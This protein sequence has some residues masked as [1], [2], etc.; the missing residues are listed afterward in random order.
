MEMKEETTVTMVGGMEVKDKRV[1]SIPDEELKA[2][3]LKEAVMLAPTYCSPN[4]S[5]HQMLCILQREYKKTLGFLDQ[6]SS[7]HWELN[8]PNLH[9]ICIPY[10]LQ[11]TIPFKERKAACNEISAHIRFLAFIAGNQHIAK[12]LYQ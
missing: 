8:I 12:E 11:Q 2:F 5:E 6:L 9:E 3:Y 10:V 7:Y 1:F 4:R